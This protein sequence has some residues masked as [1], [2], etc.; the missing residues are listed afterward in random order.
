MLAEELA[1]YGRSFEALGEAMY[2]AGKVLQRGDRSPTRREALNALEKELVDVEAL[3]GVLEVDL[4]LIALVGLLCGKT[5]RSPREI[6]EQHF[7][8]APTDGDWRALIDHHRR[9][10]HH[11]EAEE[12]DR[13]ED[14]PAQDGR[15]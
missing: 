13:G 4:A 14:R 9:E 8:A 7:T 6:L 15:G 10:E 3:A 2:G 5:G 12:E 11:D 1:N